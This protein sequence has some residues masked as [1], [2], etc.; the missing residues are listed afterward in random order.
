VLD[1]IVDGVGTPAIAGPSAPDRP[2]PAAW[3]ERVTVLGP[4]ALTRLPL[5]SEVV[6]TA[7]V[8]VERRQEGCVRFSFV[9]RG[10]RVPRRYRCQ[11]DLEID[12]RIEAAERQAGAPL[13][14]AGRAAI[15][16]EVGRWLVPGFTSTR[17]GQP[18]YAQLHL[19]CPRSLRTGAED[20]A[21][22]GAFCHLKQPQREANLHLR[23]SEYL[24]FGLEPGLV[25]VT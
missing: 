22:M 12:A 9:P 5:A 2:G 15:A 14:D 20:G 7:Q 10:S 6:F 23:L 16:E 1:S 24:P 25:Y 17:Y 19:A 4:C 18:A 8:L 3:L 13:D 11:P 21:E